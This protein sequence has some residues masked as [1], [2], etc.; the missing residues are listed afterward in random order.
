MAKTAFI[1][2]RAFDNTFCV[3]NHPEQGRIY[4]HVYSHPRPM[5]AQVIHTN[6]FEGCNWLYSE[7]SAFWNKLGTYPSQRFIDSVSQYLYEEF[8]T[9]IKKF[10]GDDF[11]KRINQ[12]FTFVCGKTPM[13]RGQIL[14]A[15]ELLHRLIQR[16]EATIRSITAKLSQ[17]HAQVAPSTC[18]SDDEF[19]SSLIPPSV[20]EPIVTEGNLGTL[21]LCALCIAGKINEDI[22]FNNKYWARLLQIDMNIV[23]SS[24]CVFLQR[25]NF[26]VNFNVES[27]YR[28]ARELQ[29]L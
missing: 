1:Q 19:D 6:P 15:V 3:N 20:F 13:S 2:H 26:D 5:Q 14:H 11:Q 27:I 10:S 22:P 7:N 28:I 25:L 17:G 24:E 29:I 12:F 9:I 4:E 16:E 8:S 18:T 23:N 21:L